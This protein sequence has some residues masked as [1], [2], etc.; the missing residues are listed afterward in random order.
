MLSVKF[1]HKSNLN[2][3]LLYILY[4]VIL[5]KFCRNIEYTIRK[6]LTELAGNIFKTYRDARFY[7]QCILLNIVIKLEKLLFD[8]LQAYK[9]LSKIYQK[10]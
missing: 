1:I 3:S 10:Y 4:N 2:N 6:I 5:L 8:L 7:I 9:I